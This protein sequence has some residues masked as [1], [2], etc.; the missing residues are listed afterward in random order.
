MS[1]VDVAPLREDGDR[2]TLGATVLGDGSARFCVWAPERE[3]VELE[4]DGRSY[5]LNRGVDGVQA[6]TVPAQ[7]GARYQFY[8]DEAGPYPDPCSRSQPDGVTSASELIDTSVFASRIAAWRPPVLEELVIYELHVGA[9]TQPGT[10]D[11]I[12]NRL[13]ALRNLG[14]RAIEV[15]PIATFVGQRG[16]GYD[17]LYTSAPYAPYGGPAAFARFVDAAHRADLG[18]IVDVVYNHL[19]PGSEALTAFGPY[20]GATETLWG[21]ALDYR[22][23]G[24]REWAIQN[25]EMWVRD[26]SVDGL[27]IDAAHAIV[28]DSDPHVLKELA[29]RVHDLDPMVLV[30]SE[31][32]AGDL[33]PI[34]EWGHDAQWADELHHAVHSVLTGEREGYYKDYGSLRDIASAL[35]RTERERLVVCAQDHDQVGNRAFGDRLHGIKLRLAA[36]CVLTSAS[37]PLLFMGEEYDEVHPFLF[38]TDHTDPAL[39]EATRDGRRREFADF[40]AF[41]GKEIPDPQAEETFLASKLE[42]DNGDAATRAY[43]RDLLLLRARLKGRPVSVSLD[44]ER[45]LIRVRRGDIELVMNFSD[46]VTDGVLPWSGAWYE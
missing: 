17:G 20:L 3:E 18:V 31:M 28:D 5:R 24:V 39:A 42:P 35:E 41:S 46:E 32:A 13:G 21:R 27:R 12:A 16:W 34:T 37:T 4:L 29:T 30:I 33:R 23:R 2:P 14:V 26:Y 38:F 44:E 10:F 6:I 36:F 45:S 15:M 43:Y 9:F 7:V 19:G 1:E 11:A 40:V 8:L 25:A 22:Q